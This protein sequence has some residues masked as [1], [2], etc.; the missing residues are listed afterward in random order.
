MEAI[1]MKRHQAVIGIFVA[2]KE[3]DAL[4]KVNNALG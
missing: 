2:W 1:L 3:A 4:K